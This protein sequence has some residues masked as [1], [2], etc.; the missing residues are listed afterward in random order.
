MHARTDAQDEPS[1]VHAQLAA[2]QNCEEGMG[3][4]DRMPEDLEV[5]AAGPG[6]DSEDNTE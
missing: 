1:R 4:P 2:E 5:L 3:W 6:D